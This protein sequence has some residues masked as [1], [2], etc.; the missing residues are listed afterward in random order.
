MYLDPRW[1]DEV[2]GELKHLAAAVHDLKVWDFVNEIHKVMTALITILREVVKVAW[3]FHEY[4]EV[5]LQSRVFVKEFEALL[6]N[7]RH[8][9]QIRMSFQVLD[10]MWRHFSCPILNQF[11]V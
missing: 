7:G 3:Q 2:V 1:A 5:V 10:L 9:N 11:S 6:A 4:M 8:Q